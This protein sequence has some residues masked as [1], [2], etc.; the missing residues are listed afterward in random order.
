MAIVR[1]LCHCP[2]PFSSS[3]FPTPV[4]TCVAF[5][6]RPLTQYMPL[7]SKPFSLLDRDRFRD[8][9]LSLFHYFMVRFIDKLLLNTCFFPVRCRSIFSPP[10]LPVS[11]HSPNLSGAKSFVIPSTLVISD[12]LNSCRRVLSPAYPFFDVHDSPPSIFCGRIPSTEARCRQAPR[13]VNPHRLFMSAAS[14]TTRSNSGSFPERGGTGG[15]R[16]RTPLNTLTS[17]LKGPLTPNPP[18]ADGSVKTSTSIHLP[19]EVRTLS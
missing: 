6:I 1:S 9:R 17:S 8:M 15:S 13:E 18:G 4:S 19:A 5:R 16:R 7:P 12:S 2:Y 10:V 11:S 14:L 3:F